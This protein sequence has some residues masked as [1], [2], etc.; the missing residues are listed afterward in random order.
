MS[1][2]ADGVAATLRAFA[3][4]AVPI[5]RLREFDQPAYYSYGTL[6]N[7][8]WE[9]RAERLSMLLPNLMVERYE[10]R[11]YM[12][13]SHMAEPDRVARA[14]RRLWASTHRAS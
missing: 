4:S 11:S 10:G 12:D 9:R 8:S 14:L 7:A 13:T 2:R 1:N 6:S 3:D 5:E